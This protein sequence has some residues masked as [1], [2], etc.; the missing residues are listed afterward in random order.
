M[1]FELIA[2]FAGGLAGAGILMLLRNLSGGRLPRWLVPVA[3]GLAM[4][5]VTVANEY[6]WYS[7]TSAS[8]PEGVVVA[9]TVEDRAIWRP[10]SYVIPFVSRFIAV[11]TASVRTNEALPGQRIVDLLVMGRWAPPRRL[12][13]VFDCN[14]GKR[15]DLVDGVEFGA[16][17]ALVGAVWY[18]TGLDEPV[19]AVACGGRI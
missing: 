13:A 3:A 18:E 12:R 2:A 11:D 5:G 1:F 4:I 8:L 10:W 6:G 19:T 17:G 15:A 16:D 9:R 7:R 14:D